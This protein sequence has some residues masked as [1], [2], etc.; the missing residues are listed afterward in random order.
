ME[1]QKIKTMVIAEDEDHISFFGRR[2]DCRKAGEENEDGKTT[3]QHKGLFHRGH[4]HF[5][6]K[7]EIIQ[8]TTIVLDEKVW[9]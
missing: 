9:R 3:T 6:S 4:G 5:I 1:S 8:T 2:A 7:V